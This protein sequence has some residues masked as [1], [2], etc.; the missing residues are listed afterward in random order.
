MVIYGIDP[1]LARSRLEAAVRAHRMIETGHVRGKWSS[2]PPTI[3]RSS[4]VPKPEDKKPPECLNPSAVGSLGSEVSSY[5]C[6]RLS[7]SGV[8]RMAQAPDVCRDR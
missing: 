8:G 3:G 4:E 6:W 2:R 1:E 7:S 5:F